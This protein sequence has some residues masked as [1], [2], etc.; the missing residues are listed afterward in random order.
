MRDSSG[1]GSSCKRVYT[2]PSWSLIIGLLVAAGPGL[3]S[4]LKAYVVACLQETD[5]VQ[6]HWCLTDM[7]FMI[8]SSLLKDH[9]CQPFC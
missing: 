6:H 7:L 2:K 1:S 8:N 9:P 3:V 5:S 4:P